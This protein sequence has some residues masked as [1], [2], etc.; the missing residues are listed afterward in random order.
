[1]PTEKLDPDL[2]R[3]L[4]LVENPDYEGEP[5]TKK[6]YTLLVLAGI[7]LPLLLMVWGWQI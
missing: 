5:L 1:M 6:D 2:A 3:R 7:I 4:K